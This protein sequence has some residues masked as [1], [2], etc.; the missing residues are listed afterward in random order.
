LHFSS[1]V[2]ELVVITGTSS[3]LGRKTA[4]ALIDTGKYHVIGAVRDL[5][6]M[7]TVA[8]DDGY[9]NSEDFTPMM[10]DLSS[11]DSVR[12]FCKKLDEFRIT[13]PVDR[14]VCN[15]AVSYDN[16]DALFSKDGHEQMMQT[17][18]LSHFL[19][20][21]MLLDSMV[22]SQDSQVTLVGGSENK[23]IANLVSLDGFKTGLKDPVAM[24][25]GATNFSAAKAFED[26]KLCKHI[27]TNYLHSKYHKLTGIRF[28][29]FEARVGDEQGLFRV[30]NDASGAKSG[31][32]LTSQGDSLVELKDEILDSKAYDIDAAFKLKEYANQITGA[33][34]P[35][36]RQVTSPCPT[37]KVIG[38][39]TKGKLQREEMKRMREL[40][41]PGIS[42]PIEVLNPTKRQRIAAFADKV[43]TV[44]L[45]QTVGRV[46]RVASKAVLGEFPEEALTGSFDEV[47]E[48]DV[49]E[50]ELAIAEQLG[51]EKKKR[52]FGD[53][54]KCSVANFCC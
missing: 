17:N 31:L 32:T 27:L 47:S 52:D 29:D 3:G 1:L 35:K 14:L 20:T 7:T 25:D 45:K 2:S 37:L 22:D 48:D 9:G 50:I 4:Q 13:K 34:W 5:E 10:C 26:S 39:V 46:A 51:K 23:K 16:S 36:I 43:A 24:A 15:A 33:V 21:S 54:S 18:F 38:A 53:K 44:I 40:G 42:E 30:V 6:K 28:N 11:F 41:R 49:L 19:M 8:N 12:N